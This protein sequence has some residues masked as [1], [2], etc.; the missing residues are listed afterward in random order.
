MMVIWRF[1]DILNHKKF[2]ICVTRYVIAI[3][4][5]ELMGVA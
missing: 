4:I 1:Y 5:C 2:A 3:T